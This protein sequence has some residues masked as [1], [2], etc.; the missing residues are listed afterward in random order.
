MTILDVPLE[1]VLL[2]DN[3]KLA[4]KYEKEV[5]LLKQSVTMRLDMINKHLT[6]FK[7][8]AD[9][10]SGWIHVFVGGVKAG[11]ISEKRDI[12]GVCVDKFGLELNSDGIDLLYNGKSRFDPEP[13]SQLHRQLHIALQ[14]VKIELVQLSGFSKINLNG[15][16]TV[17]A[18]PSLYL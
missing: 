7:L 5:T 14:K 15:D 10:D 11:L 3:L 6:L 9:F 8:K 4:H 17:T 18:S 13:E 16:F 12:E 1:N 2:R